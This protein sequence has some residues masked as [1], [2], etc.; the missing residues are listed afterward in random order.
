MKS[1]IN[2]QIYWLEGNVV[3]LPWKKLPRNITLVV[4]DA[5]EKVL[6]KWIGLKDTLLDDKNTSNINNF[7]LM[8]KRLLRNLLAAVK[9]EHAKTDIHDLLK[10]F[11]LFIDGYLLQLVW[12]SELYIRFCKWTQEIFSNG[13]L[14]QLWNNKSQNS[15]KV[16][17]LYSKETLAEIN[18]W[19]QL[20]NDGVITWYN[21]VFSTLDGLNT[22]WS[23][24][25]IPNS[26]YNVRI[27]F[28]LK[29]FE[30]LWSNRQAYVKYLKEVWKFY[31]A[32]ETKS[33]NFNERDFK[34]T[35]R[36]YKLIDKFNREK[37]HILFRDNER[38]DLELLTNYLYMSA[39]TLDYFFKFSPSP[40]SLYDWEN[41]PILSE[42]FLSITG[43]SEV[44]FKQH[45]YEIPEGR[46]EFIWAQPRKEITSLICDKE[47]L[48]RISKILDWSTEDDIK[49]LI[50]T[51]TRKDWEK[52]DLPWNLHTFNF[53]KRRLALRV[54]NL[55]WIKLHK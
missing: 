23:T 26:D 54:A 34:F 19:L 45:F 36:A 31:T 41:F 47:E 44:D 15:H 42:S 48:E 33:F 13:S 4:K 29:S 9:N 39:L 7:S 16:E 12:N 55:W 14:K 8:T 24:Y 5:V 43:F 51:I 6:D 37:K 35:K 52:L 32:I 3:L 10:E 40:A 1:K 21:K 11:E 18:K 46:K 28:P 49:N 38:K 27:G 53:N 50:V 17:N 25:R 22:V 2:D 20:L 30:D